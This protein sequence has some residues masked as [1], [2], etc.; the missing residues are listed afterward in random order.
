MA[1]S[2]A[3]ARTSGPCGATPSRGPLSFRRNDEMTH[4]EEMVEKLEA[5][6]L[7]NPGVQSMTID[8]VTVAYADLSKQLR[9]WQSVVAREAGRRP[10]AA[11]VDLGGF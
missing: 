7:A 10:S 6:L 5:L 2:R 8:G 3:S 4:A 1:L 9:H 11:T